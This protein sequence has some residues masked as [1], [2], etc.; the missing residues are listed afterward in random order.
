[1]KISGGHMPKIG[2][3][4][5]A[6][7]EEFTLPQNLYISTQRGD[8]LYRPVVKNGQKIGLGGTLAEASVAGGTL[9]LPSPSAGEVTV[10]EREGETPRIVIKIDG[11]PQSEGKYD[12][13]QPERVTPGKVRE[14]LSNSG[15]WPLFWSSRIGGVPSLEDGERPRA[16]IVN[17]VLTEPFLARGKVVLQRSW[18][19][20]IQ[21]MKYFPRLLSEYG[22]TEIILTH[23]R[24]PVA[25]GLYR[26]L[27][28]YA[29][30]H[31][32]PVPLVYPVENPRVLTR[33][34]RRHNTALK[35]ED[36]IWVI[37]V[38]GVEAIGS[39]LA[40]GLPLYERLVT[41][42]GP[43][44]PEPKHAVVR[45]G[46]PI[47]HLMPKNFRSDEVLVLRGGLLKG[48]PVDPDRDAVGFDDNGF[49]FLPRVKEREFLSFMRP[50]FKKASVLP[51]FMST[52]T[53]AADRDI[54]NS[55]RGE[56]RPCI[57]CGLCEKV[58]PVDLMPQIIHRYL[59]R[60]AFDEAMAAGLDLCIDCGLCT[61]VCPSK[62][63][64]QRQFQDVLEQLRLEH[65]ESAVSES[66]AN[67]S[68]SEEA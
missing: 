39:C 66:S 2:G 35:K 33:A 9:S 28:G 48:E 8:L 25:Q 45:I 11:A 63:E 5:S 29:W 24:D 1:M 4:P 55:L 6:S 58:C 26:E 43:G 30:L 16:I 47:A 22:T 19:R 21:G 44:Y 15:V 42:G 31:F 17:T 51:C 12:R 14:I 38:Q 10:R 34:L 27:A 32:H 46:T 23:K 67:T 18:D 50:G 68:V 60:E 13:L 57:A 20:I 49:F 61:Y 37:D 64:L 65:E 59:Y 54:S 40:E 36:V 7:V 53:G 41:L 3:R 52:I 62:I 56:R